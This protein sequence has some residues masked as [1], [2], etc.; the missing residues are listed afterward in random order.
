MA[1][2]EAELDRYAEKLVARLNRIDFPE[3]PADTPQLS[4]AVNGHRPVVSPNRVPVT[5]TRDQ[6]SAFHWR[7][8][9]LCQQFPELDWV[10]NPGPAE[11]RIC[12]GCP[13]LHE[14]YE[15]GQRQQGMWGGL[16]RA[17][18]KTW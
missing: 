10:V 18:A 17:K 11:K 12:S 9:A 2:S 14:C 8:F 3:P 7:E 1:V 6:F 5:H 15:A 4:P 13:V 16:Q